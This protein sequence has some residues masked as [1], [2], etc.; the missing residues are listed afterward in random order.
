[1]YSYLRLLSYY[2]FAYVKI[3]LGISGAKGAYNDA[4]KTNFEHQTFRYPK[5]ATSDWLIS[6]KIYKSLFLAQFKKQK[7]IIDDTLPEVAIFDGN[8]NEAEKRKNYIKRLCGDSCKLFLGRSELANSP[9]ILISAIIIL[10]LIISFPLV[11]IISVCSSNK[12]RYPFHKLNSIEALNCLFLLRKYKIKKLHFFCIYENDT[13]LMAYALMKSGISINKISSEVPLS[14][15]NKIVVADSLSLCFKYQLDE[16][17]LYKDTMYV[18][19]VQDWIP[20]SSFEID[21]CYTS[22]TYLI[23]KG[24]IG[25]YS[26]G[27]WL[28]EKLGRI[29]LKDNALDN[30]KNLLNLLLGFVKENSTYKVVVFLHPLEKKN[31]QDTMGYYNGLSKNIEL[32]DLSI[33]NTKQFYNAEVGVTLFSTLSYERLFWGFKTIIYPLGH[34]DFPVKNSNFNNVCAKSEEEL[35]MKLNLALEVSDEKF[36]E[37]NGLKDYCYNDYKIFKN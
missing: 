2:K 19:E 32:A 31:L 25:F 10:F 26:S 35:R 24:T 5:K 33:P 11:F 6:V 37:V 8:L 3:L 27:M 9:S 20:E 28:R 16:Y 18:K 7:F 34:D 22:K 21:K 36:Y 1:M 30:E 17:N 13:N 14:F 23:K 12:L 15:W 29:D 4:V